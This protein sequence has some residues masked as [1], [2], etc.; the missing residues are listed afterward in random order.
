MTIPG[1]NEGHG[2]AQGGPGAAGNLPTQE[3]R[4]LAV[5]RAGIHAAELMCGAGA[6][7]GVDV[8]AC[9]TDA[10]ALA[11]SAAPFK[12]RMG[13]ASSRGLGAG[14]DPS[15]GQGSAEGSIEALKGMV[16]GARVVFVLCGLGAGT[17]TGASPVVARCAREAARLA[18]R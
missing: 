5:G 4:V 7:P 2:G 13:T 10:A 6:L 1:M 15:L 12:V 16:T 11:G 9:H 18:R 17:G 8:V 3:I 14:G